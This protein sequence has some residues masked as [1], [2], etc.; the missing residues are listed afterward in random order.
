MRVSGWAYSTRPGASFGERRVLCL[1]TYLVAWLVVDGLGFGNCCVIRN[2][3]AS[4]AGHPYVVA[5]VLG[6]SACG[7]NDD[8]AFL[9]QD[10][11]TSAPGITSHRSAFEKLVTLQRAHGGATRA[12]CRNVF[13]RGVQNLIR[14]SFRSLDAIVRTALVQSIERTRGRQRQ[15]GYGQTGFEASNPP[16]ATPALRCLRGATR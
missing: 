13:T 14:G 6:V 9:A 12:L 16:L 10:A 1:L 15:G 5:A 4:R 7:M 2:R 11:K 3:S 8:L